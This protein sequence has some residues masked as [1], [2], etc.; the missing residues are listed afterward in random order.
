MNL[1]CRLFGHDYRECD[2]EIAG[3][4]DRDGTRWFLFCRRCGHVVKRDV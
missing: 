1:L 3:H 2:G 4:V